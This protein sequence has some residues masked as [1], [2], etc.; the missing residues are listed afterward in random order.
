MSEFEKLQRL[1]YKKNRKKWI[2]IHALAIAIALVIALASF[3]VFDGMNRTYY[4]EYAEGGQ[5]DYKVNLKDNHFFE[6]DFAEKDRS[7]IASLIQNISADFMYELKMDAKRVTFDYRYRID[8]HLIVANQETGDFIFDPTYEILP[9]ATATVDRGNTVQINESVEI[10]YR[11]Y[12]DLATQFINTYN[13]QFATSTL[14]VTL[15]VDVLTSCD[16]FEENN[17]NSYVTSLHIPLT[18]EN[19]SIFST[20]SSPNNAGN[21]LACGKA[22][23]Q[24]IFLILGIIFAVLTAILLMLLAFFVYITQNEDVTYAGKIRKLLS[25]YR[26]FIQRINGPFDITG[27]QI[28]PI[29][30]FD[31]M[32]GIRDTLQAPL[33]MCENEDQTMTQFLIPTETNILYT[34]EIKVDNYDEIYGIRRDETPAKSDAPQKF[35]DMIRQ[36]VEAMLLPGHDNT[37][38]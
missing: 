10:D 31:E 19:F 11:K 30:S 2:G 33:L 36:R 1:E 14:V 7:Y 8:A 27:Y 21:V 34:F 35:I 16:E 17:S 26:S 28:V 23:A 12:N 37:K 13:L 24:K 6:E 4:I 9:E 32:L 5:V 18:E 20:A 29:Q 22:V 38:E 3:A 15:K 25:S